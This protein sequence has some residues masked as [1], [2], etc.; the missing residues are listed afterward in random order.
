MKNIFKYICF[1]ILFSFI[2]IGSIKA[3]DS[4]SDKFIDLSLQDV[5]KKYKEN[6]S[7]VIENLTETMSEGK[8][9]IDDDTQ[10]Y[11]DEKNNELIVK[12]SSRE[13]ITFK[14]DE[15]GFFEF[16]NSISNITT[17]E[18]LTEIVL[19]REFSQALVTTII[20]MHNFTDDEIQSIQELMKSNDYYFPTFNYE[21]HGYEV[22]HSKITYNS[23][24]KIDYCKF[25]KVS[26][27]EKFPMAILNELQKNSNEQESSTSPITTQEEKTT[28]EKAEKNP[29]TNDITIANIIFIGTSVLLIIGCSLKRRRKN[30][31]NYI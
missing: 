31:N 26:I 22:E 23:T 12:S 2:S 19:Q 14:Y 17:E 9:L 24:Y 21:E 7:V 18:E 13:Y 20:T 29:S 30:L 6:I 5:V 11:F 3:S 25:L 15:D 16:E 28:T 8:L 27:K 4:N 10:V 1:A